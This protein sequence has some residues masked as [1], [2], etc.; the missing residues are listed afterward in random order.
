MADL[1]FAK[2]VLPG[3]RTSTLCGTPE[4]LAPEIIAQEGHWQ[5]A[6]W[7]AVG[8]LIHELV[9]GRCP[10]Y[11]EDRMEMYR[12]IAAAELRCPPH[13]S[14]VR[15]FYFERE[16][17]GERQRRGWEGDGGDAG[18]ERSGGAR[19]AH[20]LPSWPNTKHKNI[21]KQELRDL[22]SRLLTR[23]PALRLGAQAGGADDVKR[24]PWF[25]GFDWA[26]FEARRLPAP[27][28]PRVRHPGDA[29]NFAPCVDA[30]AA[31]GAYRDQPYATTGEF[32]GF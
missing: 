20:S 17:E 14:A 7:W 6:D 9:A 24:H 26:A 30:G 23:R 19:A 32:S 12:R 10:F 13:F 16:G 1:G 18:F 2:K 25:A 8:V 3:A 5:A 11:S 15:L 28:A 29:G 27:H 21:T 4:Y 31:G 22:L